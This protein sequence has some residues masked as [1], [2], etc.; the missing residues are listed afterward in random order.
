MSTRWTGSTSGPTTI[1]V[2]LSGGEV[3]G[4]LWEGRRLLERVCND[5]LAESE[6][7][8][9]VPLAAGTGE[10]TLDP[11]APTGDPNVTG[12][13]RLRGLETADGRALPD[14]DITTDRIGFYAG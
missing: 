9:E 4:T 6:I 8:D 12:T 10:I 5:Y 2:D 3:S 14:L 1:D 13:L 11:P 7:T